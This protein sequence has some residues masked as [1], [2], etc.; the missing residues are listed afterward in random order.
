[1]GLGRVSVKKGGKN[2]RRA[3]ELPARWGEEEK[4]NL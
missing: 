2:D 1:M 4:Q 3:P